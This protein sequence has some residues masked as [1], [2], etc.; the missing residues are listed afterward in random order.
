MVNIVQS[1]HKTRTIASFLKIFSPQSQYSAL[2]VSPPI[3]GHTQ[4]SGSQ[5]ALE[6]NKLINY[7][8]D[9]R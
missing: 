2:A 6:D 7:S 9:L 3:H 8:T 5:K 4:T 1:H